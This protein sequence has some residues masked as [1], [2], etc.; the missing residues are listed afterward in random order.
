MTNEGATTLSLEQM[1][2]LSRRLYVEVFGAG[3]LDAADEILSPGAVSHGPGT[4]PNVGTMG[5]KQQA[6][7]LRSAIPDLRVTLED[8]LA[9]GDRVASRW[10][11][12]GTN[13]GPLHLPTGSVPPT[14]RPI[15]FSEIRIDRYD[16]GRIVESWFLPDRLSLWQQ[17]GLVPLP[18]STPPD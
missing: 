17:L 6:A 3:A 15:E 18:D 7:V 11:G 10:L 1:K 12:S 4:P 16:A 9:E 2:N 14:G 8:Q 13:T 5:I